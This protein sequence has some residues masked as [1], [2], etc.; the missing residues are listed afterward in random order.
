VNSHS[1]LKLFLVLYT[2]KR[3]LPSDFVEEGA[4][5]IKERV[6]TRKKEMTIFYDSLMKLKNVHGN[7]QGVNLLSSIFCPITEYTDSGKQFS[8]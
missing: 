6:T 2:S 1:F 8:W 7:T 4:R 5:K 3:P